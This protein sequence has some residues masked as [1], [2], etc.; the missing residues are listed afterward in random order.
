VWRRL[1]FMIEINDRLQAAAGDLVRLAGSVEIRLVPDELNN[2][3]LLFSVKYGSYVFAARIADGVVSVRRNNCLVVLPLEGEASG[4]QLVSVVVRWTPELLHVSYAMLHSFNKIADH[5]T[6][7]RTIFT[8]PPPSLITLLRKQNLLNMQDYESEEA[9]RSTVFSILDRLQ[10]RIGHFYS[11]SIFW[12]LLSSNGK[13]IA[14]LPKSETDS[15]AIIQ[16]ILIDQML[17]CSIE[18]VPDE[19]PGSGSPDFVLTANIRNSGCSK[20]CLQIRNAHSPVL[21]DG[22][23]KQLPRFMDSQKVEFGIFLVMWYGT[24]FGRSQ[25]VTVANLEAELVRQQLM[26]RSPKMAKRISFFC[27]DLTLP[28]KAGRNKIEVHSRNGSVEA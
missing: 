6:T 20:V 10:G 16:A 14:K 15:Y 24:S 4:T 19:S 28:V 18:V 11:T 21:S 13:T 9:F 26:H 22:L 1:V 17:R 7:L 5:S 2:L 8:A 27:I 25:D 3:G 23:M 12:N